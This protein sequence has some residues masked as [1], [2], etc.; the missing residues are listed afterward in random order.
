MVPFA[1]G[2]GVE[3]STV[4]TPEDSWFG[5]DKVQHFTFSFLW[6]LSS[7]YVAVNKFGLDEDEAAPISVGSGAALGLIKEVRDRRQ[8]NNRFSSRDLIADCVGLL[9]DLAVITGFEGRH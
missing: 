5:Y 7:Q 2:Q 8:Q 6:V 3:D 1:A 4:T 9:C